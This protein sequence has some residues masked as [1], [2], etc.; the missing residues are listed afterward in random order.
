MERAEKL[1]LALVSLSLSAV[2]AYKLYLTNS[3]LPILTIDVK[4]LFSYRGK[5][6][7][8][9]EHVTMYLESLSKKYTVYVLIE[10]QFKDLSKKFNNSI[11]APKPDWAHVLLKLG[12][13]VHIESESIASEHL[14]GIA[15]VIDIP[16]GN[17]FIQQIKHI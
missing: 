6:L 7:A 4:T 15:T 17:Q 5:T 10:P 13:K 9:I 3:S 16:N 12:S 8:L 2:A 1:T 11:V 14:K